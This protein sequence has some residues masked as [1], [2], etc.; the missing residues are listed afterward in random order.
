[1]LWPRLG[2]TKGWM[3]DYY[4]R[5]APALIPHLRRHPLTLHRFPDGVEGTHWYE[6]RAPAHRRGSTP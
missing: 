4:T 5:V 3:V 1:V 6:T 2:L